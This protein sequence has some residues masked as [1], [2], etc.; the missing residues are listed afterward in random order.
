MDGSD[1]FGYGFQ[2]KT[3]QGANV[4]KISVHNLG[5]AVGQ[6][7]EE[8]LIPQADGLRKVFLYLAI[9]AAAAAVPNLALQNKTALTLLGWMSE[10]GVID[11]DLACAQLKEAMQKA[12]KVP[13]MG[14]LFDAADVEK[15]YSRA[16]P[17]VQ[18]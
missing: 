5:A 14:I 13:I 11:L 4:G 8:E 16:L 3:R 10:E 17:Y 6:Y 18:N 1:S 7:L 12:G 15:I 2:L 9:P